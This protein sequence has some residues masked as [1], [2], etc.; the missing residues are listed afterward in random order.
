MVGGTDSAVGGEAAL[1]SRPPVELDMVMMSAW[2]SLR[3]DDHRVDFDFV[4]R[5]HTTLDL[6]VMY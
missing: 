1:V 6:G 3:S 5:G 4:F 2:R